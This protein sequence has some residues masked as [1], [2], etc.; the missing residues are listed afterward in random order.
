MTLVHSEFAPQVLTSKLQDARLRLTELCQMLA[1][2]D[3]MGP[4][5]TTVNPP[6][7]E[8]GHIVW[9]Q[10]HWCLRLKPG[11]DPAASPLLEPLLPARRPW[12]DWLFNSSRIPHTAR[13]RAP[14]P[15]PE[16]TIAYGEQVLADVGNLLSAG[17]FD[18]SLR[19]Y[20]EL[21]LYH[22]LMHIEAWW[23][24]WQHRGL[25]PPALPTLPR[26]A[27]SSPL[28]VP[29]GMVTLGSTHDAGFIFD[30]EKWA[31]E[32]EVDAF[33]IDA[34]PVTCGA[35]AEFIAD[36]G[37]TRTSLWNTAG[38]AWLAESGARNPL[39]WRWTESSWQVRRFDRWIDLEPGEPVIHVSRFEAEAYCAWRGRTLPS[40]AQWLCAHGQ[41]GFK[42]GR[43]WEWTR[44]TFGPYAGFSPDPYADYSVPW[45]HT[46]AEARGAGCWVTDAALARPTY[47]N[48][49]TPQRRDPF[50]G[51][52]TLRSA[53]E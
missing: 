46:H 26:L 31:H 22:E 29:R 44:D 5:A 53:S 18:D 33:E 19:Y 2:D 16:E 25:S 10:E 40:A 32:V 15:T 34:H 11:T 3:W 41:S 30:N 27:T 20:A 1:P 49:F 36:G 28:A 8:Y 47:R 14:L 21:C 38:R 35:Y 17:T 42:L 43:C 13:W 52:R 48:F 9:F 12:A 50:I 39:Y 4:Y 23:M 51:F 6:L 7:W 37:Y 45:F 24:M